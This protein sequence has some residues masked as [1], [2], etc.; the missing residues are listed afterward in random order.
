MI[1]NVV[2]LRESESVSQLCPTFCHP[3]DCSPPG[4]SVHGIL[5]ARILEWVAIPFSK[6]SYRQRSNPVSQIAGRFFAVWA[7]VS[8]VQ[9]S[10]TV[11]H[12]SVPFQILFMCCYR[13]LSSLYYTLVCCCSVAQLCPTLCGLMMAP[14]QP[15]LSFLIS[16]SLLNSCPLIWWCHPT[17]SSPVIPISSCLQSFPASR[18]FLMSQLFT[19]GGQSTGASASASVLPTNI[20]DWLPLRLT[21]LISL[22]SKGLSRIFTNDTV[23][24]HKFFSTQP[25]LWSTS[26]IIH[27][28]WKN[29]SFDYTDLCW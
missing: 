4:F 28:Y 1:S 8:G 2:R 23:Q 10:D 21:G 25:S 13:I 18:S 17:I 12:I 19:S 7:P 16:Q 22:Q 24:K 14:G 27:D 20:Q 26:N 11:I 3:M 5:Q 29:D 9:Q 15:S 6:G